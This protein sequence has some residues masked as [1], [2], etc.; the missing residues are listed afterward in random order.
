MMKH[1]ETFINSN[2]FAFLNVNAGENMKRF[3]VSIPKDLKQ[4]LNS[5]P[6]INWP[7]VAKTGIMRKLQELEGD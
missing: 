5:M 2:A 1:H 4:R 7:E 3:T 6:D